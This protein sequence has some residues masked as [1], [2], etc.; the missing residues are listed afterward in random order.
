MKILA[1]LLILFCSCSKSITTN[2]VSS[3]RLKWISTK[4]VN[5]E[6][7]LQISCYCTDER[8]GP[9]LIKVSNDKIISVNNLP[10]DVTKTGP[11]MTID[12]L[13][14][15]IKTSID[16]NPYIKKVE[17]NSVLGYPEHVYFD[18][19]KEIADEEVGFEITN[20][21]INS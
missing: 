14:A 5:Y 3:N 11:L 12:E 17:Y 13:I 10:Y 1:L 19:A 16:K 18:F 4:A 8:R 2:D 7:T 15:Y 21:K 9:H 20:F 6:F